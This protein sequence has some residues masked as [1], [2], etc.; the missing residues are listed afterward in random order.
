MWAT[1]LCEPL[2]A[3]MTY[4]FN[5]I[6]FGDVTNGFC[7]LGT[8]TTADA[9][10]ETRNKAKKRALRYISIDEYNKLTIINPEK[11]INDVDV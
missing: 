1:D 8:R 4:D 7:G 6:A 5:G 3:F 2:L 10:C 9:T 11:V